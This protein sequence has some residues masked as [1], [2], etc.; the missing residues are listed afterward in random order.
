[1][2]KQTSSMKYLKSKKCQVQFCTHKPSSYQI[3]NYPQLPP[4]TTLSIHKNGPLYKKRHTVRMYLLTD[5]LDAEPKKVRKESKVQYL[6][7]AVDRSSA[8]TWCNVVALVKW[9]TASF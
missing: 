7:V 3:L 1:M 8:A 6:H 5:F 4:G 9:V 2:L